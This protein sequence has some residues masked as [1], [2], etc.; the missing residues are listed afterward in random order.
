MPGPLQ[1]AFCKRLRK[2][3]DKQGSTAHH[4]TAGKRDETPHSH[5]SPTGERSSHTHRYA[6]PRR[7]GH[8]GGYRYARPKPAPVK[9]HDTPKSPHKEHDPRYRQGV[10]D[11]VRAGKLQN[12]MAGIFSGKNEGATIF[13]SDPPTDDFGV[14]I[15]GDGDKIRRGFDSYDVD[16]TS[17]I[18]EGEAEDSFYVTAPEKN[19]HGLLSRAVHSAAINGQNAVVVVYR[20]QDESIRRQIAK[21]YKFRPATNIQIHTDNG[22]IDLIDPDPKKVRRAVRFAST[23]ARNVKV[24]KHLMMK[25]LLSRGK[26]Y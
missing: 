26:D 13:A 9:K 3:K 22:V 15:A 12:G 21:D 4:T 7:H 6:G 17:G 1:A 20:G 8:P 24:T 16:N 18:W 19:S 10:G 14:H 2:H 5:V 25:R 11:A 23:Q